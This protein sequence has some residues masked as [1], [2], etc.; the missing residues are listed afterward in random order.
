MLV[1]I[2]LVTEIQSPFPA[3]IFSKLQDALKHH[4]KAWQEEQII[5]SLELWQF[6]Q[7]QVKEWRE[8]FCKTLRSEH[9]MTLID[10]HCERVEEEEP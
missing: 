9:G 3:M 4:A 8:E 5:T 7:L 6:K 2:T 1:R 10:L